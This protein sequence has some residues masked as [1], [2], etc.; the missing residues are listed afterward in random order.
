MEAVVLAGGLGTRLRALVPGIPKV[1][2]PIAGKPFMEIVLESL[3]SAGFKRVIL[4]L[5]YMADMIKNHF[6]DKFA[7][8]YLE[9]IVEDKPLGT[10]G[11][12]RLALE[13]CHS[14]HAFIFNGDTYLEIEAEK[15]EELWRM[16]TLPIVVARHVSNT[17]RFGRLDTLGN[18]VIRFTEKSCYGPGLI[19]AGCY[20]FPNDLLSHMPT[21]MPYAMWTQKRLHGFIPDIQKQRF[22]QTGARCLKKKNH[23]LMQ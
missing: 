4:S 23:P 17:E 20:V 16:E 6:G 5:G 3:A 21:S 2:A 9:Y 14:D 15:I 22:I 10:G 12:I 8:L 1:M 18:K 13:K 11:A 7:D 19:N